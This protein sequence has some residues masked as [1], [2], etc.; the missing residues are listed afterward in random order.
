MP[1]IGTSAAGRSTKRTR[2]TSAGELSKPAVKGNLAA[3]DRE[4]LQLISDI[5]SHCHADSIEISHLLDRIQLS[6]ALTICY[7]KRMTLEDPLTAKIIEVED[8]LNRLRSTTGN[9]RKRN[10]PKQNP[11]I[12]LIYDLT[13]EWKYCFKSSKDLSFA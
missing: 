7:G 2:K 8:I 11:L 3:F 5:A 1:T 10:F 4:T 9:I 12:G 13:H 6:L